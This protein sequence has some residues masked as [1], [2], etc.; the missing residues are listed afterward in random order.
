[1]SIAEPVD[2][3]DVIDESKVTRSRRSRPSRKFSFLTHPATPFYAIGLIPIYWLLGLG[4]FTFVIAA[5]P[6]GIALLAMKP[7]RFPKGFGIWFAFVGWMIASVVTIEPTFTRFASFGLRIGPTIAGTIIFLYIY[8]L[9]QRYLP[10]GR[11]LGMIAFIFLFTAILGGYLGLVLGET[12]FPTLLSQVLP[13][14]I[15][16]NEFVGVVIQPPFA[17]TQDF[18]GLSLIH[19]SEPTRPY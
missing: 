5:A 3:I 6:M 2:A 16:T 9:P 7:L 8:N 10:T 4:F 12:T 11:V 19:I 14:S 17:Q 1:M 15:L 13:R 18:L